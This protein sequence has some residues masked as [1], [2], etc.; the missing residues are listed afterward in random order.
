MERAR[1]QSVEN[2]KPVKMFVDIS[3]T[4]TSSLTIERTVENTYGEPFNITDRN[5]IYTISSP[6]E[7]N[8]ERITRNKRGMEWNDRA[9]LLNGEGLAFALGRYKKARS[10]EMTLIDNAVTSPKFIS[11]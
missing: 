3:D 5:L 6:K 9:P 10:A 1:N 8:P 11:I 4:G 2:A 7:I